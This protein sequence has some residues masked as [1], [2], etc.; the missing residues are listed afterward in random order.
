MILQEFLEQV[1]TPEFQADVRQY[2]RFFKN[3][4]HE[5]E[6]CPD[7]KHPTDDSDMQLVVKSTLNCPS[8][9]PL[10]IPYSLLHKPKDAM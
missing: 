9:N 2:Q 3:K 1:N 5:S 4:Y 10:N 7:I 8:V 6:E